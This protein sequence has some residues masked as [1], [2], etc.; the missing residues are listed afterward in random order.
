VS[1]ARSTSAQRSPR[2]AAVA[3]GAVLTAPAFA[4][5]VP[6]AKPDKDVIHSQGLLPG[7]GRAIMHPGDPLKVV[8]LEQD[9]HDL[10]SGTPVLQ[11]TDHAV[12]MVNPD[13]NRRRAL[14]MYGEGASFHEP[15]PSRSQAWST[16]PEGTPASVG[17]AHSSGA[18]GAPSPLGQLPIQ[19]QVVHGATSRVWPPILALGAGAALVA[20]FLKRRSAQLHALRAPSQRRS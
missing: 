1:G 2:L 12:A 6:V 16:F 18:G 15:L 13:E 20:L 19:D 17:F 8:G 5:E 3:L 4:Q 14:A 10:R 9:G 11:Q 7:R